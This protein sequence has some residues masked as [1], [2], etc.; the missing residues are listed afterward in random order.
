MAIE[1][2]QRKKF[3]QCIEACAGSLYRVA[4]RLTGNATLANEL[5]QET[6]LNAWRSIDSLKDTNKLRSWL[7]AIM[8]NQYSKIVI[9]ENKAISTTDQIE[10]IGTAETTRRQELQQE[11]RRAVQEAVNEL[12][13]KHRL[14]VL[15]VSME[16]M[17]VDQAAEILQIPRGT[18]LSRL[19]RGREK[20]KLILTSKK[21]QTF[22]E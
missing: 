7:F 21:I 1:A 17:T 16:G 20:L 12:D 6:Y 9:K 14:P 4:F 22:A 3:E 10:G 2:D 19:S 13:E 18:V 15:L 11:L 5:V 8:K